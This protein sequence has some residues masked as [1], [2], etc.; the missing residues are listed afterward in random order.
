MDMLA[1]DLL[2]IGFAN[3]VL[4][5]IEMALGGSPAIGIEAGDA[6]WRHEFWQLEKHYILPS[7][8]NIRHHG[9]TVMLDRVL[10]S[11][12]A[13]RRTRPHGRPRPPH[14]PG[15]STAAPP[16]S[17]AGRQVPCFQFFHDWSRTHVQH[18]G[19]LAHATRM[20]GH[21]DDLLRDRRRLPGVGLFQEKGPPTPQATRPA[22]VALLA[23]RGRTMAHNI[24]PLAIGTLQHIRTHGISIQ[25]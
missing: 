23:S 11:S 8:K 24:R 12:R 9:P 17:P 3:R 2:R 15:A 5:G 10:R 18:A 13:A 7:P 1:C 20:H 14:A 19:G 16:D 25:R 22:S 21:L 6:T 4:G